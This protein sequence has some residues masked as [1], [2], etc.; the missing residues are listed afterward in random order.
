MVGALSLAAVEQRLDD[1]RQRILV[2]SL[3]AE[4][5]RLEELLSQSGGA[6]SAPR[7][8]PAG[9]PLREKPRRS[10]KAE[11]PALQHRGKKT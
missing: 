9:G 7:P 3:Q 10:P 8:A 11:L 4:A 2:P 6:G 5:R 1:A